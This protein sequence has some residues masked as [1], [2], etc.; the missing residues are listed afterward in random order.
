M[1]CPAATAHFDEPRK[2]LQ[3]YEPVIRGKYCISFS[4]QE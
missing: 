4:L 2:Y 1:S 3:E